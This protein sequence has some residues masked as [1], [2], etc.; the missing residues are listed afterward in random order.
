M[1]EGDSIL[2]NGKHH[3]QQQHHPEESFISLM[4][5]RL[6]AFI[7]PISWILFYSSFLIGAI[8]RVKKEFTRFDVDMPVLHG[9]EHARCLDQLSLFM[10]F[11]FAAYLL[12]MR[13]APGGNI[14]VPK[15]F[16]RIQ[17]SNRCLSAG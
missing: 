4:E 12:A 9:M 10:L 8:H 13:D 16:S 11:T 1:P 3:Q 7:P 5:Q 6:L 2:R 17:I 14:E 15:P